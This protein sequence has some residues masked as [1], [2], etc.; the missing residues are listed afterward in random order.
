MSKFIK[1]TVIRSD[2]RE[3]KH[4]INI[5]SIES[6]KDR[7]ILTSSGFELDIL[8]STEEIESQILA[9]SRDEFAMAALTGLTKDI[10]GTGETLA[11]DLAKSVYQ[12]ADEML[13]ERSK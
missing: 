13:K 10:H 3:Q 6:I 8:E 9:H 12:I 5:N 11:N 7:Q 4:S 1:V 2:D